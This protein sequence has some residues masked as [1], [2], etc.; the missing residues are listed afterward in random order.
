MFSLSTFQSN[1]QS[2]KL[3]HLKNNQKDVKVN[4][5][6]DTR[7]QKCCFRESR[8]RKS[9]KFNPNRKLATF[10]QSGLQV[11]YKNKFHDF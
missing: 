4:A 10:A 1:G 8:F 9:R 5:N 3:F 7:I 11:R 2:Q 6:L